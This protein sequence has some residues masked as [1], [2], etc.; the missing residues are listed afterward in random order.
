MHGV[1]IEIVMRRE[2]EIPFQLAGIGVERDDAI[3]IEVVAAAV[4]AIPIGTG[5]ADAPVSEIEL[6]IVGAGDPH[7]GAASLPGIAGPG[8]VAGLARAGDGV[9]A[10]GFLAGGG[11]EGGDE[12][13]DAELAAGDS[14]DDFVF[15]DQRGVREGVTRVA[16]ATSVSQRSLPSWASSA[17]RWA[18]M[19][20]M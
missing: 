7:G 16:L 13:A 12:T 14:H 6:G 20:P 15:D 3:A 11:V 8:F 5:V 9:E 19:V 4:V 1:V 18:S 10:P 2:L 17:M